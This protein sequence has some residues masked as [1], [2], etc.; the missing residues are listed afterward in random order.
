MFSKERY[1][2]THIRNQDFFTHI[3]PYTKPARTDSVIVFEQEYDITKTL[4]YI[5]EKNVKFTRIFLYAMLRSITL[6]PKI[7]RFVSGLRYYQRN[8]IA[9][10]FKEEDSDITMSFSPLLPFEKFCDNIQ[11]HSL[12]QEIETEATKTEKRKEK[13]FSII[14]KLPR[15]LT[16]FLIWGVKFLDY[17]N[18][19]PISFTNSLPF[20]STLILTTIGDTD[21]DSTYYHNLKIGT[22]GIFCTIGKI[23][24]INGQNKVKLTFTYDDR[25]TSSSYFTQAI[26]LV[27]NL[28]E[29]PEQLETPL[30]LTTEQLV[31]LGLSE[32]ELNNI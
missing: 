30:E 8:R 29:N 19:L 3:L 23:K 26:D 15:F 22:C 6:M 17:H 21:I 31:K 27:R 25:I 1:D 28:V 7:N 16:R 20:Y 24:N 5:Q 9:F 13:I 32:K 4:R 11:N 18:A 10:T 2:G 14:K 12:P